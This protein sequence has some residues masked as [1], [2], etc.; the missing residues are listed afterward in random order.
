MY[1]TVN[2]KG[3]IVIE[4]W[5]LDD[6]G[7]WV[8]VEHTLD[9]DGARELRDELTTAIKKYVVLEAARLNGPTNVSEG[10]A[11]INSRGG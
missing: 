4:R 6:G 5:T 2:R 11:D 7:E 8:A 9:L 10:S 1:A 3:R